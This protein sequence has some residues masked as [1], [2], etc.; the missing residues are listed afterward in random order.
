[1]YL[2]LQRGFNANEYLSS[3]YYNKSLGRATVNSSPDVHD[4]DIICMFS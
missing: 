2:S 1:M 4:T 3:A